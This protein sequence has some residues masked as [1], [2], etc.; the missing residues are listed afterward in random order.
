MNALKTLS[1]PDIQ[2]LAKP[3]P[4]PYAGIRPYTI[5]HR[6]LGSITAHLVRHDCVTALEYKSDLH[7]DLCVHFDEAQ[8]LHTINLCMSFQGDVGLHLRQSR[9]STNL[10]PLQYHGIYAPETAYD[11]QLKKKTHGFHLSIDLSYYANLL[12]DQ[13]KP[14]AKMKEKLLRKEMV[15]QGSGTVNAAMKQTMTDIFHNPLS[16]KLQALFREGKILELVALQLSHFDS[17]R[18]TTSPTMKK[19]LDTFHD[20]RSFLQTHFTEELSLKSL[21]KSFGINEFKLKKGFKELFQTTIFDYIHELKMIHARQLL[22]DQKMYVNEVSSVVGYKNPNH[23][24]TAF[25]RKF[26]I[27]PTALK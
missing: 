1:F 20:L 9:F 11:V 7:D 26:G 21:S 24:S 23:F 4:T 22:L 18:T 14:M 6:N 10:S 15:W 25:K 3:Q 13:D 17:Q 19:D 2:A 16:G 27:C 8:M 5:H 12:C